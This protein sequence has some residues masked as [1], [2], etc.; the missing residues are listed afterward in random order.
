MTDPENLP[1]PGT[2]ISEFAGILTSAEGD[3]VP[4]V[5]GGHAVNLW[6]E[7]FMAQGEKALAAFIPFTS[8]DLDLVG[9]ADLLERLH[10]SHRGRLSRSEPRSPVLGRLDMERERGGILRVEVLHMVNGLSRDD[11]SRTM[12]L[13]VSET[14]ARVLLPHVILKAKLE[15]TLTID[16]SG[17]NDVKHVR[18]MILCV[19]AFVRQLVGNVIE[20]RLTERA[21]VNLLNEVH[22]LVTSEHALR[23]AEKWNFDLSGVWP[24]EELRGFEGDKIPR[25]LEHRFV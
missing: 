14:V 16:Q 3:E 11:L 13:R 23:S 18:M 20:G 9:S 12:E 1:D 5:V 17:R 21:L 19:N 6:S 15:N 22:D 7:Y 4:T 8:K 25:W 24:M 10:K 2:T